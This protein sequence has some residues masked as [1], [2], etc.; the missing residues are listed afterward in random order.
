[1]KHV[2]MKAAVLS[3]TFGWTTLALSKSGEVEMIQCAAD[4]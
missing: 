1:M 3:L 4:K 2:M